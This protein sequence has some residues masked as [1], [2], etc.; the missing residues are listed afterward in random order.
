MST[1]TQE[2][3]RK[4]YYEVLGLKEN[5]TQQ[6]ID[7]AY[8][9]LSR[10]YHPEKNAANRKEAEA[11]F[12]EVNEAYDVLSNHNIRSHYDEINHKPYTDKDA[13]HTFE[14]FYREHGT[15]DEN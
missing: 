11:K 15:L 4:N 3:Q 12:H 7:D 1:Q 9:K 2:G 5:A 6:E 10:Q 8:K 13:D 14:R